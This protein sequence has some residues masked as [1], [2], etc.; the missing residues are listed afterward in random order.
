MVAGEG[1]SHRPLHSRPSTTATARIDVHTG[2]L[3]PHTMDTALFPCVLRGGYARGAAGRKMPQERMSHARPSL[4]WF[5]R[6]CHLVL[7][8]ETI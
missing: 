6:C 2:A 5:R 3:L 8:S 1:G 7:A 4:G